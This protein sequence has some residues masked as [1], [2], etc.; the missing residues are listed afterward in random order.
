[1]SALFAVYRWDRA[2]DAWIVERTGFTSYAAACRWASA[3]ETSSMPAC[4]RRVRA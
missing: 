2:A 1:M 3:F 4:V